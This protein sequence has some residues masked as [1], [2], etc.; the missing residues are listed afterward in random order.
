V[1]SGGVGSG[2]MAVGAFPA[3]KLG[4]VLIKQ[5]SKPIANGIANRARKS[6]TFREYF[7]IP[8]AQFFHWYDVKVRMRVLNLGKVTSVPKM[9][10]KKAIETGAQLLSEFILIAIGSAIVIWEYNRQS[11]KEEAK[12]EAVEKEKAEQKSQITDLEFTV[13]RQSVQI[14]ELTRLTIAIRDDIQKLNSQVTTQSEKKG[15]FGGGGGE[16]P[17][18]ATVPAIPEALQFDNDRQES[19]KPENVSYVSR[20]S[21]IRAVREMEL[22]AA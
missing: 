8:V 7:C 10:D 15:W 5:I 19:V 17:P 4:L 20:G 3:A 9:D 16:S 18:S 21:I 13:A 11:N 12:A 2:N 1:G 6:K 22:H 14:K